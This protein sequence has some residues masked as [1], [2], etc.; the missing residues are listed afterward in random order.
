MRVGPRNEAAATDSTKL[1]PLSSFGI[2]TGPPKACR[3]MTEFGPQREP[4]GH[5]ATG[6]VGVRAQKVI[7][8]GTRKD[9]ANGSLKWAV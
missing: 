2:R 9:D 8:A 7:G 3:C 4:G 6:F 5:M 1:L